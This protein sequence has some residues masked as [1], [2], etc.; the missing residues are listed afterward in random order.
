LED[1]GNIFLRSKGLSNVAIPC[2]WL[3][4][5]VTSQRGGILLALTGIG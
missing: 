2:I 1:N 3:I 4:A 5:Y